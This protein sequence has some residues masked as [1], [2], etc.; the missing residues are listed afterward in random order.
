MRETKQS[1]I[2]RW[3]SGVG[4]KLQTQII[5]RL[6]NGRFIG[7]LDGLAK[8]E[9][10]FDL[11]GISFPKT[12]SEY[13]YKGK[14]IKQVS[15]SLS[16]KNVELADVDFTYCDLQHTK[17]RHCKFN[18]IDFRHA[19]L[20]QL[21]LIACGFEDVLFHDARL[22]YSFM[23][24]RDGKES[25]YFRH[26]RFSKSK[27]NETRFSFPTIEDCQFDNCNLY[28]ADFDGSRLKNCKFLGEVNS[29]WFR[30]H[31]KNEFEPNFFFNQIDKTRFVNPMENIDF[32]EAT[33][34][35]VSFSK[36]LDLSSCKFAQDV[37]FDTSP[38]MENEIGAHSN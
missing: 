20:Q 3:K 28:A 35:Y 9:G 21:E 5:A 29:P 34:K 8:V 32:T 7:D 27:L 2:D 23:N 37:S 14:Q 24:I 1:L 31:S 15:G 11:R 17:W 38:Q 33:L 4:A 19:Q 10:K 13:D 18:R 25:G 30:R 22:S 12:Y 6:K 36:D 16:F 26:V